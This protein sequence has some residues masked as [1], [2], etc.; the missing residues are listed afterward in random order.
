LSNTCHCNS[1]LAFKSKNYYIASQNCLSFTRGKFPKP[2]V[3]NASA[4]F[5]SQCS[6]NENPKFL[7]NFQ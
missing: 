5:T 7:Q 6:L 3:K 1:G 2:R 4:S